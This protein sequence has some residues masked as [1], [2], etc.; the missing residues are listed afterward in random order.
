MK[1]SLI[2]AFV[3]CSLFTHAQVIQKVGC[4]EYGRYILSD[5]GIVYVDFWN[6]RAVALTPA[7]TQGKKIVDI[8]G[9]L[10]SAVGVD[11][12]GYAWVFGQGRIDAIHVTLDTSG[13][14]FNGNLSCAGYF[15]TYTTLKSDGTIWTWGN[16]AWH[17]FSEA[18]N[19]V[20]SKPV[21]LKMP[22]GVKFS[23][24]KAGN[25]L[26]ALTTS[27]AVYLYGGN[28]GMPV[29]IPLPRPASDIAASHTGFY[30]AIVPDDIR[31]SKLGYPY[32]FG[33]ESRYFGVPVASPTPVALRKI[34][35]LT[36][37]IRRIT[38]NHNTIHFIDS[39]G[40]LF[41]MGDNPDGEVGNGSELVNHAEIYHP[42]AY[43][44]RPYSWSWG[45]YENMVSRP[46]QIGVGI[47]W[48]DLWADNSYAF[49]HY[50]ID[51]KNNAY[52]W[53]RSKSWVGGKAHGSE[54]VY[55]NGLDVLSPTSIDL[56][57]TP[58]EGFGKFILY[59]CNAGKDQS[60]TT[61][62][63]TLTG[64]AT[65]TTGYTISSYKW[66]HISGPACSIEHP[67]S[68]IT[69]ITGMLTAGTY[70]FRLQMTD[71]NT[72]TISDTVA[73]RVSRPGSSPAAA[74]TGK[75]NSK[76]R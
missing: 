8:S 48:K 28:K 46:V 62:T 53:G 63:T 6:G 3:L 52:F 32:G 14:P 12:E 1:W 10:Y 36:A 42:P 20:L 72:A 7:N 50:A 71:N 57:H 15:G 25:A 33:A 2:P 21:K 9:A 45:K 43:N 37:P 11:A 34:W 16:D 73:I 29:L 56:F 41:G 66:T 76:L 75:I 4:G 23:K 69:A 39:L 51:N 17:L 24:I 65:P 40:R 38:A 55:P 74:A 58:N 70:L 49:Y 31:K 30:I 13:S 35:G 54:D 61:D 47:A 22:P 26:M 67:S 19:I 5:D 68:P 18:G 64:L 59:T 60:I 44:G 27:G